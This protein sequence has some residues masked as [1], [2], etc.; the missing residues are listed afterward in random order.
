[1]SLFFI[2]MAAVLTTMAA[3]ITL[4]RL[5]SW[6]VMAKN[7]L[8]LDVLYTIGLMVVLAGTATG[9]LVAIMS[10]LIM[11]LFLSFL[12][13]C[14]NISVKDMFTRLKNVRLKKPQQ[15]AGWGATE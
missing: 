10:G 3:I 14:S 13:A 4:S 11:A 12:R 8:V 7:A 5:M 6:R 15:H 9:M 1:M 2:I